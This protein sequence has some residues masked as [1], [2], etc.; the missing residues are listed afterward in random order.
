MYRACVFVLMVGLV[1]NVVYG[2]TRQL[3]ET[4]F[5][6]SHSEDGSRMSPNLVNFQGYLTDS[7]GG[8]ITGT[9]EMDFSIHLYSSGSATLWSETQDVS[10]DHSVFNVLLGAVNPIPHDVFTGG[11]ERWLEVAVEGEALSPRTRVASVGYALSSTYSDTAEY[12]LNAQVSDDG[13]WTITGDDMYSNV[14]GHLGVGTTSPTYYK[15]QVIATGDET[16][17]YGE[18]DGTGN[19]AYLGSSNY[20]MAAQCFSGVARFFNG[21]VY[22]TGDIY[23]SAFSF[24]IDHPLDPENRLLRHTCVESPVPLLM[25][26][27]KVRLDARGE[28]VIGMPE[29]F[30]ALAL[31]E[32][33]TV[34]LTPIGMPFLTGY[35]W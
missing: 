25:Y 2:G 20:S 3:N 26:R 21:D 6:L 33:A 14:P 1:L 12:A 31:E 5:T 7:L 13:D 11:T 4:K 35:E 24:L 10:V 29:Y 27:G 30:K 8:E 18:D 32:E 34:T 22:V 15:L 23:K 19:Y 9:L 16:A 17:V 28:A